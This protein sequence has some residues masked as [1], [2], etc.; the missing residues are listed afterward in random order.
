MEL[1]KAAAEKK[2]LAETVEI[3]TTR[4]KLLEEHRNYAAAR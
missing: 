4:C 2:E 1:T 3:L